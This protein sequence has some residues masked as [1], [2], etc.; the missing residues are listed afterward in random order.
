MRLLSN[1]Y[2]TVQ[3]LTIY[4]RIIISLINNNKFCMKFVYIKYNYFCL[5]D[6][7]TNANIY[8]FKIMKKHLDDY[9]VL[10]LHLGTSKGCFYWV[11]YDIGNYIR[12]YLS[13]IDHV[14]I[15]LIQITCWQGMGRPGLTLKAKRGRKMWALVFLVISKKIF[16]V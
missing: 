15:Y 7:K 14:I 10:C 1:I 16:P 2:D 8:R 12:V 5:V 13:N 3:E 4:R 9:S 6:L 11:N